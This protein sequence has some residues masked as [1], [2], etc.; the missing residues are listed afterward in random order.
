MAHLDYEVAARTERREAVTFS[1]LGETF[2]CATKIGLMPVLELSAASD[3]DSD[4]SEGVLALFAFLRSVI[5]DPYVV[6][7][8]AVHLDG[9]DFKAGEVIS[10]DVAGP[11]LDAHPDL[12]VVNEW[13]RF[14]SH[15][16]RH[17]LDGDD[18]LGLV[19][20]LMPLVSG[21]PTTPPSSSAPSPSDNGR[22][23]TADASGALSP[24]SS[25]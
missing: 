24:V 13:K 3:D 15:C 5:C 18:L 22:S 14:R 25:G 2:R 20:K 19:N 6:A 21:R 16:R 11:V 10:A 1:L 7:P 23:L 8:E 9:V 4:S 17:R 12:Q